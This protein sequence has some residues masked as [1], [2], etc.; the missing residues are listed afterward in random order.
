MFHIWHMAAG[1]IETIHRLLFLAMFGL[2]FGLTKLFH[3]YSTRDMLRIQTENDD[4][5]FYGEVR[6]MGIIRMSIILF[7]VFFIVWQVNY[8][9]GIFE[10]SEELFAVSMAVFSW[11][12]YGDFH[13]TRQWL[14]S[15]I[16]CSLV[17]P[18]KIIWKVAICTST[19]SSYVVQRQR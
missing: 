7:S 11:R 1:N 14:F 18:Q 17:K 6:A 12:P 15:S 5:L 2:F 9:I 3:R 13:F 19:A 10:N 16:L 4:F 8:G